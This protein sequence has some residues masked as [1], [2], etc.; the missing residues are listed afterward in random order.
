MAVDEELLLDFA[1][2]SFSGA[3][4]LGAQEHKFKLTQ[5]DIF[6]LINECVYKSCSYYQ[7]FHDDVF[8]SAN[9]DLANLNTYFLHDDKFRGMEE[10]LFARM[11]DSGM[12]ALRWSSF[13]ICDRPLGA[14]YTKFDLR[15]L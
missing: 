9:I 10:K 5:T 13:A 8:R 3:H 15:I 2:Q 7:R 6:T 1:V 11:R 12:M 4:F 14:D